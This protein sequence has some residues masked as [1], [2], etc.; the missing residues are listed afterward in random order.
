LPG[1]RLA[2]K[3]G[4]FALLTGLLSLPVLL[5]ADLAHSAQLLEPNSR[6]SAGWR[7]GAFLLTAAWL[8]HVGWAAM[9]GGRWWH[10]L[11]PAPIAFLKQIW[12]P[13]TWD[14]AS[15]QLYDLVAGLQLPKLW[16]M[17]AQAT[18]GALLWLIIPVSMMII[19]QRAQAPIAPLV[20][21]LGAMLM[22]WVMFYLPFFQ[23]LFAQTGSLKSFLAIG[24]V[25]RNY[26]Y[27]PWAHTL[28]LVLLSTL[29]IPLYLLRI[30]AT[31]S[32]LTWLPSLFFALLM[33]PTKLVLGWATG[34]SNRRQANLLS[35]R[36]WW[37]RI[38]AKMVGLAAVGFYVGA[39]YV[40][41]LIA[42]Q[43]AYVM[44][45]QHAFLVP[46]PLFFGN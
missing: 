25:R 23:L 34:C 46:N 28:A 22:A 9:R 39:L 6:T 27:A 13:S 20:G 41:Q 21:I 29:A 45:F 8:G 11:W 35:R 2:G 33:L 40:A 14:K 32:E 38:P 10:F 5:V 36:A 26:S 12:R 24:Q 18:V 16:W 19:G 42:A 4:L 15:D 31:P 30:E 3:L 7:I 1:L 37:S 43:G 17:G 44:Y